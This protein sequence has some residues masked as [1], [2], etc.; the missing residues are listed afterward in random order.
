M[1]GI[2][3][4]QCGGFFEYREQ[5]V[6]L[7][8]SGQGLTAGY[9]IE[10]EGGAIAETFEPVGKYHVH[11]YASMREKEPEKWPELP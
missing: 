3:C 6:A 2:H 10:G 8:D 1:P 9:T 7:R 4:D 5:I 11:C